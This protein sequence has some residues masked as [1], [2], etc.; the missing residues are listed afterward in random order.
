MWLVT[1]KQMSLW[2][3]SRAVSRKLDP[4]K[5]L[6][7]KPPSTSPPAPSHPYFDC[8]NR[9]S[10]AFSAS[11]QMADQLALTRSAPRV[12]GFDSA[13]AARSPVP[14]FLN[15]LYRF[16]SIIFGVLPLNVVINFCFSSM[17]SDPGTDELIRWSADGESFFG[18]HTHQCPQRTRN[19][20]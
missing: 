10:S 6:K 16:V 15:K 7:L 2:S 17:V 4:R 18:M 19:Y 13:K 14:A 1:R 20:R 5:Y 3:G 9:T 11:I 8:P 12:N